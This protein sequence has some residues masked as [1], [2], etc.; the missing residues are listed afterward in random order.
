MDAGSGAGKA[1]VGASVLHN[2]AK[3]TGIE[4]SGALDGV[5]Q[6]VAGGLKEAQEAFAEG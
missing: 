5:A 2:F 6:G 3:C 4:V 1:V